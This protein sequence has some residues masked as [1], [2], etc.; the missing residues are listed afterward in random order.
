MCVF[1]YNSDSKEPLMDA[2]RSHYM[3]E[4]YCI[5]SF[6][7]CAYVQLRLKERLMD[8]FDGHYIYEYVALKC[9]RVPVCVC[10]VMCTVVLVCI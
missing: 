1:M 5:F 4:M 8:S 9:I 10:V 3:C 6:C 7:V 2:F